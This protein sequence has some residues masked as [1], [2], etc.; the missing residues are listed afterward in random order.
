MKRLLL[1]AIL[2][3]ILFL[4]APLRAAQT[5]W[6]LVPVTQVAGGDTIKVALNAQDEQV[7]LIGVEAP[8][9]AGQGRPAQTGGPEAAAFTSACLS[10][11]QVYLEFDVQQRDEAGAVLAYVWLAPPADAAEESIR[12]RQYNARLL[13]EGYARARMVPPNLRYAEL[14]RRF[15]QEARGAGKG[16]WGLMAGVPQASLEPPDAKEINVYITKTG[17]A[18]HRL[19]CRF[20]AKS[21]IPIGLQE[22]RDKGYTPCGVCKPPE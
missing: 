18:Y 9:T 4:L 5:A 16:L 12:D 3:P 21:S 17:V 1:G 14:Y 8:E 15:E 22:A 20:L 6:P 13:L 10:Y 2:P 7:R 19:G 11:R